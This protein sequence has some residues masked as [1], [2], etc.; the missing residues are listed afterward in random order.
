[1]I[2]RS[3]YI[4]LGAAG[5]DGGKHGVGLV[6]R[7]PGKRL[8]VSS[9]QS[10]RWPRL[11]RGQTW[12]TREESTRLFGRDVVSRTDSSLEAS[13]TEQL[14]GLPVDVGFQKG[15]FIFSL[16]LWGVFWF[17]HFFFAGDSPQTGSSSEERATLE[18]INSAGLQRSFFTTTGAPRGTVFIP[19]L[20][21]CVTRRAQ[22]MEVVEGWVETPWDVSEHRMRLFPTVRF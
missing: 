1:M 22:V 10:A 4:G 3:A 18:K 7:S 8:N 12:H 19:T 15:G 6:K 20:C 14:M 21:S 11:V 13:L 2:N 5:M 16:L 9:E 17:V